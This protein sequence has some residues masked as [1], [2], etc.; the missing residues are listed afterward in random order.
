V[1]ES[2]GLMFNLRTRNAGIAAK[3]C[4]ALALLAVA[5]A[6]VGGSG[7]YA[8]HVYDAKVGKM[9][10]ASQRAIIGEKVNGLLNS[11]VM[12]SRGLYLT[13]D[14]GE[15][16]QFSKPL[17]A[18]L[19]RINDLMG[20]WSRLLG[21][22]QLGVLA[23]CERQV[24]EF[25]ALRT[26]LVRAARTSG[27]AEAGKIG[28]N[29]ANRANRQALN[30]TVTALARQNEEDVGSV[31]RDLDHFQETMSI[32]LPA[33]T[34][35]VILSTVMLV[36]F[37]VIGGITRPLARI[38]EA[39]ERLAAGEFDVVVPG[40]GKRDEIG[41]MA[42]ALEV[43]RSQ[44]V[45]NR[46]LTDAGEREQREAEEQKRA[47]L[48]AMA[49][50]IESAAGVALAEVGQRTEELATIAGGMRSMTERTGQSAKAAAAAAGQALAT[51]QTV[52]S[53][54]EELA[55]SIRSIG[56]Q[57]SNSTAMVVRA[58]AAGDA[59]RVAI[60]ALGEEVSR[61]GA[62]ADMI[63]DVAKRTNLLALNA[64]IE[65]ARAGEAGKGFAV[66]ASEVK[67]L[68]AQTAR[69]TQQIADHIGAVRAATGAALGAVNRMK[70]TVSEI[71]AVSGSIAEAVGQQDAA[72]VE[73]ARN[74]AE[75]AAAVSEMNERNVE[76]SAEAGRGG[77]Y[78]ET[79]L[80]NTRGLANA[81][82]D[83]KAA[84]IRAVR[85]SSQEVDRRL[86]SRHPVDLVAR[87]SVG[88][89]SPCSVHLLDISEDG[90]C[91]TGCPEPSIGQRGELRLDGLA[92]PIHFTVIKQDG[93]Q[94]GVRLDSDPAVANA[95]R[96]LL[97]HEVKR[98]A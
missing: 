69:S 21:P 70:E 38:I 6:I 28:N 79:V 25:I 91:F 8:I 54:A 42:D 35:G 49:T 18:N 78:A 88:G 59:T 14:A 62:V 73:I 11:V 23:D 98:A 77:E 84:I 37:L 65:A 33:V 97:E 64:T 16:E 45:E 61:I 56:S 55:A 34:L 3:L 71:N 67:Q 31:A 46:R 68:A 17:L 50:N 96:A 83:L 58:V 81:V 47:A 36:L 63:G 41:Q 5:A 86:F 60:D 76:V 66:V 51:A 93:D 26:D 92:T 40:R 20:Q 27:A 30:A 24:R 90:A 7:L 2:A 15:I 43:F 1:N 87:V 72:T 19:A 4:G 89:G 48:I 12:D 39:M 85:T 10:R 32:V 29:A 94:T 13:Y 52:A 57:V 22:A 74:V 82:T 95:V 80:A 53:A 75:T 44:A 9:E